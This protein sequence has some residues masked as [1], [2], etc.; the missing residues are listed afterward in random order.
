V[1]VQGARGGEVV[2]SDGPYAETKEALT[3]FYLIEAADPDEAFRIAP[4]IPASRGGAGRGDP[5]SR[6]GGGVGPGTARRGGA[7]L[8]NGGGRPSGLATRPARPAPTVPSPSKPMPMVM[9]ACP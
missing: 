7:M 5:G 6:A 2:L 4:G 8:P 9:P 3:G 1:R